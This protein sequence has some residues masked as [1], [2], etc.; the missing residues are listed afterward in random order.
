MHTKITNRLLEAVRT[1]VQGELF[2]R[3][4][5]LKGFGVRITANRSVSFFA[6]GRIRR[7]GSK[8]I[9]LG[10]YPV[11]SA[12]KARQLA[13]EALYKLSAGIDPVREAK[14][15][16]EA[17]QAAHALVR[18]GSV[19]LAEVMDDYF[20]SRPIKSEPAY[21]C[22]LKNSF[23]DWLNRPV[24]AITRQDVEG[25]YRQIAFIDGHKAQAAKA[26]R[27][28]GAVLNFAK[29]ESVKGQPLLAENPVDVLRDKK[30]DRTVKPR[31]QHIPLKHVT[32]F[33]K[34]ARSCCTETARDLLLFELLTGLRDQEAKTLKWE[35]VDFEGDSF[36]VRA[37]KN[38]R[39]H[40]V[41]LA[42]PIREL[43]E[44]RSGTGAHKIYVFANQD[45]SGPLGSIRKQ[46]AR[47]TKATGIVFTH[48]D[49]RRTFASLLASELKVDTGTISR[50]LNH[51]P[52][53][54]TERHYIQ[55]KPTDFI[56]VYEKLGRLVLN[57]IQDAEP[58]HDGRRST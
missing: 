3:D 47:V 13:K 51:S 52:R 16:A 15:H 42:T 10:R 34:A 36:V 27:C 5:I 2:I 23:G 40:T 20:R 43:L 50:L 56:E 26:M 31:D 17:D 29:G 1:P 12:A 49:L 14:A 4:T 39:D 19:T 46:M 55:S 32:A 25:R 53:G 7:Q 6:E 41:P 21:R 35:D 33:V 24:R 30:I 11:V 8:R 22:V 18:A 48:H 28:L 9:G 57:P 44:G 58:E 37:T 45:G 54:V 38:G